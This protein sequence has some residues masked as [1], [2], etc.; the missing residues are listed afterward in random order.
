[1]SGSPSTGGVP[2]CSPP[3]FPL[4]GGERACRDRWERRLAKAS[5]L[6][7]TP[8]RLVRSSSCPRRPCARKAE[9]FW[10][11]ASRS[12]LSKRAVSVSFGANS[13]VGACNRHVGFTPDIGLS[14]AS[15][16]LPKRARNGTASNG[17][18]LALVL[19]G[20]P[21]STM[22]RSLV[23]LCS[24]ASEISVTDA[25]K[26]QYTSSSVPKAYDT[27]F[28]PRIFEPRAKL[29]LTKPI[30]KRARPSLTSP[31]APGPWH[32]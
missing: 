18:A 1:M 23:E 16:A 19:N 7:S 5:S 30:F 29:L 3:V 22:F 8:R 25:T 28:V 26:F 10:S 20:R 31:L 17:H 11:R 9:L 21:R 12:G 4:H 32:G 2:F 24:K 27:F 13:E 14:I 6:M 15:A